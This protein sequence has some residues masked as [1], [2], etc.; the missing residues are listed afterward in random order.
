MSAEK[1]GKGKRSQQFLKRIESKVD[2]GERQL[3]DFRLRKQIELSL[4]PEFTAIN[5]Q[6]SPR[7]FM[8]GLTLA[9]LSS[10]TN[11]IFLSRL[12]HVATFL[13]PLKE[14]K[15]IVSADEFNEVVAVHGQD[16]IKDPRQPLK[17][18]QK[19]L[20]D[21]LARDKSKESKPVDQKPKSRR[22]LR[23][24]TPDDDEGRAQK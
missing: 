3:Q 10:L 12:E 18:F 2:E 24:A 23:F 8:I 17:E 6:A 19:E 5:D 15:D 1:T 7:E 22:I 21:Y 11:Q 20:R 16:R 4:E 14:I 13:Q 9:L